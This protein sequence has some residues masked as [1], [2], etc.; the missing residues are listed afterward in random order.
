[1]LVRDAVVIMDFSRAISSGGAEVL[2]RHNHYGNFLKE[3]SNNQCELI[4]VGEQNL[5]S[6]KYEIVD[7]NLKVLTPKNFGRSPLLSAFEIRKL[8]VRNNVN[9]RLFVLGDPW[10]SGFGGLILKTFFYKAIPFQLQIHAD[11][12]AVGWKSS[13]LKNMLKYFFAKFV[14]SQ[15]SIL[16]F[17]STNQSELFQNVKKYRVDIIP[18]P[19]P[20]EQ[21]SWHQK[22]SSDGL[23]FGFFGRLHKDRGTEKLIKLFTEILEM[24][25][26]YQL[27]IGGDGPE[28]KKVVSHLLLKFPEQ[29]R[30]LGQLQSDASGKFWSE[31]DL[32][33]SL[34]PF[35]SYGRSIRESIFNSRPVIAVPS[36]GVKDLIDEVGNSWVIELDES[37]SAED[38]IKMAI[39]LV[40]KEPRESLPSSFLSPPN[41]GR[42]LAKSWL[43][44]ID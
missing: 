22:Q 42:D 23:I 14:I 28:R 17:V 5:Q 36:S 9:P 27:I 13:S 11:L 34:A 29:V 15:Y 32:L 25:Q 43:E 21:K 40:R 3:L 24:N 7:N 41:H 26:G 18:V 4:I 10:K 19:Y 44:I 39:K 37:D 2:Q 12:F 30:M 35:E 31:I 38:L 8:L 6:Y 1:M 33:L 20:Q 16:R